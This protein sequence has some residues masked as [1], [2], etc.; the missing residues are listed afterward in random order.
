MRAERIPQLANM[1]RTRIFLTLSIVNAP[2]REAPDASGGALRLDARVG[3][4]RPG[5]SRPF[6]TGGFYR[7]SGS[8]AHELAV[9]GA[10]A[11]VVHDR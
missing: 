1:R 6:R 5:I 3:A 11:F 4:M 10:Q 9:S 2:R 8:L 7:R